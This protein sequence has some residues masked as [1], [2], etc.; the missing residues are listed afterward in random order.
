MRCS[1]IQDKLMLY[2]AHELPARELEQIRSHLRSC[3]CCRAVASEMRELERIAGY[4][5]STGVC[6][7]PSLDARVMTAIREPATTAIRFA[8]G[9]VL[10]WRVRRLALIGLA[11]LIMTSAFSLGHWYANR[12]ADQRLEAWQNPRQCIDED[13]IDPANAAPKGA[14]RI[15]M[16]QPHP[17]HPACKG[18]PGM[19]HT[20]ACIKASGSPAG[21]LML[22]PGSAENCDDNKKGSSA[23]LLRRG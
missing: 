22:P 11:L 23:A 16:P 8:P 20:T 9:A 6:A 7:P 10:P 4:A 5:M 19:G 15:N 3:A 21:K 2:Q 12:D 17:P 13:K 18:L 1:R 14:V